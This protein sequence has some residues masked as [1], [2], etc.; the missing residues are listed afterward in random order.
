MYS[1]LA[2]TISITTRVMKYRLKQKQGCNF[3]LNSVWVK[4]GISAEDPFVGSCRSTILGKENYFV[5]V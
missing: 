2:K 3:A 5:I 1:R 4:N